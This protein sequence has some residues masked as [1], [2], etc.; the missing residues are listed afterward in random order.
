VTRA[1]FGS[2]LVGGAAALGPATDPAPAAPAA[3]LEL[4]LTGDKP[5]R[6]ELRVEVD[7]RPVAAVWDEALATLFAFLDRNSDGSLDSKEA[8]AAPS[9][10]A[11]RQALGNGFT[12]P[13]GAAPELAALDADGD[14]KASAKEFAA[15]YRR[16]G[17]GNA[18]VG[19]GRLPGSADL[20]AA[21]L[22]NLDA[23]GD[24]KVTEKELRA[25]ADA[26]KSLDKNDDEL[27]GAGELVPKSLYPGAAGTTLLTAP[28]A[29]PLPDV[30]GK[31]PLVLLPA[32]PKDTHWAGEVAKRRAKDSTDT[33]TAA[34]LAAWRGKEPDA[35]V[36]VKLAGKPGP[37]DTFA[38]TGGTVRVEGWVT[39]GK[40]TEAFAAARRQ[41]QAQLS[42]PDEP[43]PK[44]PAP[45]GPRRGGGGSLAWLK[46]T[47]DRNGDGTLD[48]K[49]LDAWL[50]VQEQLAHGQVL[51]SVL[52]AG[53][54]LFELL[55][56]NHDGALS[57][58]ELRAAADRLKE[59]GCLRD[60]VLNKAKIPHLVLVAASRGYPVSF[61]TDLR[62]GPAWFKAMDRN[63]DGDVSRREFT[64]PP[65]VFDKLDLDKDGLLSAAEAEKADV[66]K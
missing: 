4:V 36:V 56:T 31:L 30:L 15:F 52:D 53:N 19:V 25:A 20:T 66:K 17:L 16:A 57:P 3:P 22:K 44:A 58:R 5:S 27:I 39:E 46:P 54:G 59:V 55:D 50:A 7:G 24:G 21:L 61:G 40:V 18:L 41:F 38:V 64:G 51:L 8:A 1:L 32:D 49:E 14:G 33:R 35:R 2:L 10:L 48:A 45:T 12:P 28:S 37:G 34:D 9:A 63:G 11:L 47:A 13:T 23:D 42:A 62:G 29:E 43:E 26:L 6:V 60:G 65:E